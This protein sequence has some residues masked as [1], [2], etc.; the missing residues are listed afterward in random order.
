MFRRMSVAAFLLAA[1]FSAAPAFGGDGDV[2]LYDQAVANEIDV[3]R[4]TQTG[5]VAFLT[6]ISKF[7]DTE[8][9][10]APDPYPHIHCWEPGMEQ[11]GAS[12]VEMDGIWF[13]NLGGHWVKNRLAL[14]LWKVR[15]PNANLRTASEFENDVTLS[16]W[17]DWDQNEMWDKDEL[18]VRSSFNLADR[19]PTTKETM[20]VYYLTCFR[21]PD[22]EQMMSSEWWWW[23]SQK[24]IRYLWVR[25]TVVYDDPDVSP[26]GEQLFGEAEDYRVSYMVTSQKNKFK[27]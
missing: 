16:M 13:I 25:G 9:G 7:C 3:G 5:E 10:P 24:D 27:N 4:F 20:T 14:V 19:F 22:I 1:V 21:V 23:K 8:H 17:V 12:N 11:L 18:Q 26:D 2:Y 15:I 6:G